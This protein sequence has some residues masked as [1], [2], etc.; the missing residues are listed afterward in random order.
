M[1]DYGAK[2][3]NM[4]KTDQFCYRVQDF[5]FSPW[6]NRVSL[7]FCWWNACYLGPADLRI[8]LMNLMFTLRCP[9]KPTDQYKVGAHAGYILIAEPIGEV[10]TIND[11][12]GQSM[13]VR[14]ASF[15]ENLFTDLGLGVVE[16]K[17]YKGYKADDLHAIYP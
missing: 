6:K 4:K 9:K 12:R 14:P 16:F 13:L 1:L 8:F 10:T 7:C 15:Y 3:F 2:V 11:H 17:D 5:I